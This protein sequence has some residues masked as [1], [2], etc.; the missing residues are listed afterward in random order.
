M[1]I[2]KGN[3]LIVSVSPIQNTKP[4][5]LLQAT[6]N[7]KATVLYLKEPLANSDL[8]KENITKAAF[9]LDMTAGYD[10]YFLRTFNLTT[11]GFFSCI[12]F[13]VFRWV[14]NYDVI[15]VHGH[16]YFTFWLT[17]LAAKIGRKKLV[18]TTDA[19]YLE[20]TAESG[21]WKLRIKPL[22]LRVLY[23]HL[24]DAVFVMSSTSRFFLESV[25]IQ[26]AKI[27]VIPYAV[28]EDLIEQVSNAT[29][30]DKMRLDLQIPIENT[31]FVFCA[32]FISRKRP[33]DVLRAFALVNNERSNLLMI[34]DGPLMKELK[35][36]SHR[37][38]I[39]QKVIFPGLIK[40]SKLPMYYTASD[41]LVFSSEH[42]PYGLPVNEAMLCGKPVIV[43]DRIGARLDLVVEGETGWVYPVGNIQVL[44]KTMQEAI[45]LNEAGKLSQLGEKAKQKMTTWS[46]VAHV[47]NQLNFFREKGWIDKKAK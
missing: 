43:S 17:M 39:N 28:D 21:G 30:V 4:F 16:S 35:E 15:V 8:D 1:K 18:Q 32:K 9:D 44:A 33:N 5:R 23:N 46:S 40:Y 20:A 29:D 47:N 2:K 14:S 36:L 26:S 31:V 22:F 12:S 19:I 3:I 34:G 13:H 41:V 38:T 6:E 45:H 11:Q 10:N 7:I 25:G 42:E 27:V 24:V 37:L